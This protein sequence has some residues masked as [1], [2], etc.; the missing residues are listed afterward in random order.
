MRTVTKFRKSKSE[1]AIEAAFAEV[2]H[3]F[4]ACGWDVEFADV[5]ELE[6][7]ASLLMEKAEALRAAA[8]A[9]IPR[10]ARRRRRAA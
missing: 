6:D 7:R 2:T 4:C 10:L 1:E 9:A 3:A 8:R 5:E